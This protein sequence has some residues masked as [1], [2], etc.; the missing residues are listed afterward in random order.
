M[1]QESEVERSRR[2]TEDDAQL[3]PDLMFE[4]NSR[5]DSFLEGSVP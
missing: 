2:T 1:I 3:V 5:T 4:V